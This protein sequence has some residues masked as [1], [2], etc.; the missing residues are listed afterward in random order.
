MFRDKNKPRNPKKHI[1]NDENAPPISGGPDITLSQKPSSRSVQLI[2]GAGIF[3]CK[4]P[5]IYYVQEQKKMNF[6]SHIHLKNDMSS[7]EEN[8][9]QFVIGVE[10]SPDPFDMG[11]NISLEE[12]DNYCGIQRAYV[13]MGTCLQNSTLMNLPKYAQCIHCEKC[14]KQ[15]EH[16]KTV[17]QQN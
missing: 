9:I 4:W 3:L 5:I 8:P 11:S 16:K 13:C 10:H 12:F 14:L 6:L 15:P 2:L 1:A 17:V 7:D